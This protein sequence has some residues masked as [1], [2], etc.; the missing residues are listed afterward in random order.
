MTHV[1]ER[2]AQAIADRIAADVPALEGRAYINGAAGWN[3]QSYPMVL[4]AIGRV[5]I[6][7]VRSGTGARS[8]RP[9]VRTVETIVEVV[10]TSEKKGGA[11]H[12]LRATLATI[13]ASV[14][15]ALNGF[16]DVP[17]EDIT[18]IR[19]SGLT[20]VETKGELHMRGQQQ[21]TYATII[22][23]VEGRPDAFAEELF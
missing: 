3:K 17:I 7:P 5:V 9:Q 2:L 13:V 16:E 21:L 22:N 4:V 15:V 11:A 6:D 8:S 23:T 12:E 1:V 19:D 20:D 14:E 10:A 18:L